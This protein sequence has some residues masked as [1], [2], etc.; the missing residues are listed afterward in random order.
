[1]RVIFVEDVPNVARTGEIKEVKPGYA[2]NFLLPKRLAVAATPQELQRLESIRKLGMERQAKEKV[3]AE[4]IAEQLEGQSVTLKVRSGPTGRLYGAVTT[5]LVA[6][7]LSTLLEREV[8]RRSVILEE[9]IHELGTFEARV[10]L[11]PEVVAT[12]PLVVEAFED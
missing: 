8:D 11:H 12:V 5:A 10:R 6:Q 2:R 4:A 1:M 9:T 3:G 7:E